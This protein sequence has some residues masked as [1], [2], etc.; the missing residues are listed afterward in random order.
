MIKR[1][2]GRPPKNGG[3]VGKPSGTKSSI[4][5]PQCVLPTPLSAQQQSG[6]TEINSPGDDTPADNGTPTRAR[7]RTTKVKQAQEES[8]DRQTQMQLQEN[9]QI[10]KA[11]TR[12]CRK[13]NKAT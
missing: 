3:A 8:V 5:S 13:N 2:R 7:K 12:T 9:S 6:G 4:K 11:V 1:K 10:V